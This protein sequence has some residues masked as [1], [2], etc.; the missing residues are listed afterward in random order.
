MKY[1]LKDQPKI[2]LD[3]HMSKPKRQVLSPLCQFNEHV[4][5]HVSNYHWLRISSII[6]PPFRRYTLRALLEESKVLPLGG[7]THGLYRSGGGIP[8]SWLTQLGQNMLEE[9]QN[10][11]AK[12]GRELDEGVGLR[13]TDLVTLGSHQRGWVRASRLDRLERLSRSSKQDWLTWSS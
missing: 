2:I 8:N 9:V 5:D 6:Y 7:M 10:Y 11:S 4:V 12:S 1:S 3:I 13:L